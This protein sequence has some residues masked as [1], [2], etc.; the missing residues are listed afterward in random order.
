VERRTS[1]RSAAWALPVIAAAIAPPA[2]GVL[3]D[4]GAAA[5]DP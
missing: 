5:Q 2:A 3:D 4:R 1:I